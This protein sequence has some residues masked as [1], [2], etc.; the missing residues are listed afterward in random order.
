MEKQIPREN[1]NVTCSN[2]RTGIIALV[3][4]N[5]K[6]CKRDALCGRDFSFHNLERR[7]REASHSR[8]SGVG[9]HNDTSIE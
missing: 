2:D 6:A 3:T 4:R 7:H 8:E 1:S 5:K 9:N